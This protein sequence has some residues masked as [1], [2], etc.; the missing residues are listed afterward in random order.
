M[1]TMYDKG[2]HGLVP[3]NTAV[4]PGDAC[5][6]LDL[7]SPTPEE[8]AF[9]EKFLGISIPTRAEMREIEPSSRLYQENGAYY[10][11]AFVVVNIEEPNPVNSAVT[12]ILSGN[13]LVTV[14]YIE[15]KAFPMFLQRVERGEVGCATGG[16]VLV[17][18]LDTLIHRMADLIERVQDEVDRLAQSIF[19]VR[20]GAATRNRRLD[21]LLRSTGREGDIV[22]RAQESAMSLG[23]LLHFLSFAV[24]ESKLDERLLQKIEIADR[25][26]SA[27]VDHMRFLTTRIGFLLEAT[28]GA[29]TIEQNQIIK[30]FSVMAVMLMPPTLVASVYGMN[31]RNMPELDWPWG[32][33]LALGLM[34]L[35]GIIPYFYFKAKRWL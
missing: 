7:V 26:N 11:T 8:D 9:V 27:L 16:S 17:G 32:Y 25:D 29:I 3:H 12:F 33:P 24:R 20:G 21:V 4:P 2:E 19:V 10:M 5:V 28:L 14:R 1:L 34:F 30:L 6:W 13:R 35:S 22:A 31:F 15:T 23:R 18:L